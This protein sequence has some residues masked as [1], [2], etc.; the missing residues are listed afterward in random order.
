MLLAQDDHDTTIQPK[1]FLPL[2]F[3]A[4]DSSATDEAIPVEKTPEGG[5]GTDDGHGH[6]HNSSVPLLD[7]WPPQPVGITAVNLFTSPVDEVVAA[8]QEEEDQAAL[9]ALASPLVQDALGEKYVHAAT[10]RTH[11]K[12]AAKVAGKESTEIQVAYFSYTNNATVAVTVA[13]GRVTTVQR[14]AAAIYQPEPTV[15][16]RVRAIELARDYF[17]AKGEPRVNQLRGFVI[18]AYRPQ[19]VTGFYE[20][21]VLYVSFHQSLDERPEYLAWVDLSHETILKA[22]A[23]PFEQ[24]PP[25]VVPEV[26]PEATRQQAEGGA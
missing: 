10:I 16:E 6:D 14:V 15:Q 12:D 7:S 24:T 21:R 25:E 3:M 11:L 18:M 1:L 23:D 4:E 20:D 17:L 8:A 13:A 26:A 5:G 19:G 22:I 2:I 9:I